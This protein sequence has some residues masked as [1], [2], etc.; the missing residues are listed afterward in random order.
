[1]PLKLEAYSQP[2]QTSK[3]ARFAKIVDGCYTLTIF[4]KR[5]MLDICLGSEYTT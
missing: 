5:Y 1:M 4:T 3:M 2:Y